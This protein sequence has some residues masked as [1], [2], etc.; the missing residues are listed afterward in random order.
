MSSP[1]ARKYVGCRQISFTSIQFLSVLQSQKLKISI[2]KFRVP[3]NL[4]FY[5]LYL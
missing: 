2:E 3:F 4:L 5:S 1:I